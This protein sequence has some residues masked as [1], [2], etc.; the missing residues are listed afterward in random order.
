LFPALEAPHLAEY[1]AAP[2]ASAPIAFAL[3]FLERRQW[4]RFLLAALLVAA[5]KEEMALIGLMLGLAGVLVLIR[6]RKR[7][8]QP[9][10]YQSPLTNARISRPSIYPL[11][12]PLTAIILCLA[13]F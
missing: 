13:W 4:L 9:A 7:S 2:L 6:D 10:V 3:L 8:S 5:V 12:Y 1:H 11:S